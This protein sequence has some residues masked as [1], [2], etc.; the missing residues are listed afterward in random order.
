MIEITDSPDLK[1]W[2]EF[3]ENHPYGNIFQTPEMAEVYK[4]T[5]NYE[6]VALAAVDTNRNEILGI[7]LTVR[8]KEISG[9]LGALSTR[10]VIHGG[11]LV[12]HGEKGIEAT[13][14][15]IAQ[16]DTLV[17]N[18]VMYTLIRNLHDTTTLASTLT[19]VGYTYEEHLNFLINLNRSEEE[20][21]HYIHKSRR[22]GI[23][24]AAQKGVIIKE[25]I[26]KKWLQTFYDIVKE[27]Y[28]GVQIPL[29]DLSLFE[30]V[31][32]ILVPKNM[33]K[34]FLAEFEG[35]F[36][37]GRL[38]TV[39]KNDIFDWYAGA[40]IDYLPLYV[41]EAIVWH[42]L[43][44]GATNGFKIFDFGGAGS[45][46]E[47]YGVREFKRRFGGTMVNFGRY[48]KIYAPTKMKIAEK[49]FNIYKKII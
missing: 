48:K 36:I 2:R 31:F 49:G 19:N 35:T 9:V 24:R 20:I 3:I 43:K 1:Q 18:A 42:I 44:V 39:Y 12:V 46:D 7:L 34:F 37:G 21:W 29:V 45:P 27:T 41:N 5:K 33:A 40:L 28:K 32:D 38:I 26:D 13:Q 14:A 4:R 30:S 17:R 47:E 16:H 11:P 10:S 23:N 15:L 22:K 8:I 6:P 25:M